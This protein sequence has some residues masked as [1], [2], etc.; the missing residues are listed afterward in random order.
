MAYDETKLNMALLAARLGGIDYA[1]EIL[2]I[3]KIR[4]VKHERSGQS[5]TCVDVGD[6]HVDTVCTDGTRCWI[7]SCD[8]WLS[9]GD[10]LVA[11]KY[12][13]SPLPW[14]LKFSGSKTQIIDAN[15]NAVISKVNLKNADN[16]DVIVHAVNSYMALI[17]MLKELVAEADRIGGRDRV[18]QRITVDRARR[19][20]EQAIEGGFVF[21]NW[22]WSDRQGGSR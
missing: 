9:E 13:H 15:Y 17:D 19:V 1:A 2:E 7:G 12:H 11:C 21:S 14:R 5:M 8:K 16:C 3:R 6:D 10:A 22:L 4:H 20:I 18:V